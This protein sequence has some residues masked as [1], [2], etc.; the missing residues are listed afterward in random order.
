MNDEKASSVIGN[1]I[2]FVFG[3]ADPQEEAAQEKSA[4]M[5]Y[6]IMDFIYRHK[7]SGERLYKRDFFCSL[8]KRKAFSCTEVIS[9]GVE[10]GWI[11]EFEDKIEITEH[12][13]SYEKDFWKSFR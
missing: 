11:K 12:G 10:Q 8:I 4:A 2:D 5:I 7:D 1:I 9:L 13:F 6:E 3:A